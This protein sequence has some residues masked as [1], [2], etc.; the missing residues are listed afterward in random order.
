MDDYFP[1][2]AGTII[3]SVYEDD[4]NSKNNFW[5]FTF[6]RN[7]YWPLNFRV[8]ITKILWLILPSCTCRSPTLFQPNLSKIA[9]KAIPILLYGPMVRTK[10]V[11][12]SL[13]ANSV[14]L[15]SQDIWGK[16]QFDVKCAAGTLTEII[17]LSQSSV[18]C[19]PSHRNMRYIEDLTWVLMFYWIY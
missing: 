7:I 1:T 4:F 14:E 5:I 10:V 17:R 3:D 19:I 16:F 9:T 12:L 6:N 8:Q 15:A 13:S 2:E 18:K 11:N